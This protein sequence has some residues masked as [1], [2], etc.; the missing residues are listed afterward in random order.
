MQVTQDKDMPPIPK[1]E[2]TGFEWS[3]LIPQ[4]LMTYD[5]ET[6]KSQILKLLKDKDIYQEVNAHDEFNKKFLI[7][8]KHDPK[9]QYNELLTE[10][11]NYRMT[12]R[13]A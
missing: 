8:L 4:Q 10:V 12:R 3:Q 9:L 5:L 13:R 1:I 2:L 11:F 6:T 7:V